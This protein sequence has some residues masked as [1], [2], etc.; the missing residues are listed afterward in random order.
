MVV[1]R[2]DVA[3]DATHIGAERRG[4]SHPPG[5]ATYGEP[6]APPAPPDPRI[7]QD[8][9]DR[10]RARPKVVL[11]D[12]LDGGVR[13]ATV[14]ELARRRGVALPTDDPVALAEW[15]TITPALS[16][17]DAWR[18]FALV[19][20]VLDDAEALRRVAAEAV[21]DLALD[22]V[23][24]AEVR[25]A[26]LSHGAAGL[27]G[28]DAVAAVV[29]GLDDGTTATGTT[30]GLVVCGLREQGPERVA[31]AVDL[32][33]RW[34]GR[35]VVGVDLAGPEAGFPADDHADA[36]RRAGDAGLGVTIHAGEMDGV[37]SVRRALSCSP[38]RLGHGWRLVDD[39]RVVDGEIVDLGPVAAAVHD[40]G[41]VL[42]VCVTSNE[43]L[44]L[45]VDQHPAPLL[46]GAGFRLTANPD[47]RTI[48]TTTT[49][50]EHALLVD[51]LGFDDDALDAAQHV[52]LAAA[53]APV[54]RPG[55]AAR[56]P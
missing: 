17:D 24:H 34:A 6:M 4:V 31:A 12:H 46:A 27:S 49:S 53:F 9:W 23:V 40:S 41:L 50:R 13:P 26:P 45:P 54:D 11:H 44:G 43:C 10:A 52:A 56:L 1:R 7:R 21:E 42:E 37:D 30:A 18:R 15:F 38:D 19:I 16:L 5:A 20:D 33:V 25:F 28:D 22:G 48:T 8:T 14:I 35:G 55:V 51:V 2:R 36:F 47:D 29:Q 3:A 39:C 32:A